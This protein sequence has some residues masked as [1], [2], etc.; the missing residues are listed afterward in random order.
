MD[1]DIKYF[2]YRVPVKT[3][4]SVPVN[5]PVNDPEAQAR[6][7]KWMDEFEQ[8]VAT[9]SDIETMPLTPDESILLMES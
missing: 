4:P 1:M 2:A 7:D 5:V 8:E 3:E 6:V 9:E